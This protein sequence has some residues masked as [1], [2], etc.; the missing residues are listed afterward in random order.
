MVCVKIILR[1][2]THGMPKHNLILFYAC[3]TA[4]GGKSKASE[5]A[6]KWKVII[7]NRPEELK[8]GEMT[9]GCETLWATERDTRKFSIAWLPW[10][11]LSGKWEW[12]DFQPIRCCESGFEGICEGISGESARGKSFPGIFRRRTF[13]NPFAIFQMSCQT[14]IARKIL[15]DSFFFIRWTYRPIKRCKLR[16]KKN[17]AKRE[18]HKLWCFY[19]DVY[20]RH[21]GGVFPS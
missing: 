14:R 7:H 2:A 8:T 21:G 5:K 18:E 9:F 12:T 16:P 11:V 3:S 10:S 13:K 19:S 4:L 6:N 17:N 20:G 1:S 15:R